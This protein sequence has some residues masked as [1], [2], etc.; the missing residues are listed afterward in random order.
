MTMP[1]V[2]EALVSIRWCGLKHIKRREQSVQ[3]FPEI[4]L[5]IST[6]HTDPHHRIDPVL[7]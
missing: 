6:D 5:Q 7:A 2:S 3:I 1:L 4:D